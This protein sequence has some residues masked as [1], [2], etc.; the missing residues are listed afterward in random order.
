MNCEIKYLN[1][2]MRRVAIGASLQGTYP[3]FMF[4]STIPE[5]LRGKVLYSAIYVVWYL[6]IATR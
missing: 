6:P 5:P 2:P 3:T 4:G 1:P